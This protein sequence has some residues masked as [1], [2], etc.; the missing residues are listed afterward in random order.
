[1]SQDVGKHHSQ[2][3]ETQIF[4]ARLAW[5]SL[6]VESLVF[7]SFALLRSAIGCQNSHDFLNQ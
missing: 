1:M 3:A 2:S 5:L 7:F 4:T 6:I